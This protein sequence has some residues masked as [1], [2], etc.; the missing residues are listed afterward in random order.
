MLLVIK[1]KE[2]KCEVHILNFNTAY[3]AESNM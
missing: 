2:T 1:E 3:R